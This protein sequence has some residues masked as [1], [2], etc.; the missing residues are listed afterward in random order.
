MKELVELVKQKV[1]VNQKRFYYVLFQVRMK[2]VFTL[3]PV[4]KG[5]KMN[6]G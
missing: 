3:K 6:E 5:G 4:I 1:K 2:R